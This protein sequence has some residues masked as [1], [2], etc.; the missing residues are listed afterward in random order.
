M[1]LRRHAGR[2]C[3]VVGRTSSVLHCLFSGSGW[4]S[5]ETGSGVPKA[6]G[7]GDAPLVGWTASPHSRPWVCFCCSPCGSAPRPAGA[8]AGPDEYCRAGALWCTP[9]AA[10]FL[11]DLSKRG[12]HLA[13][14][15]ET[16]VP[17]LAF[18]CTAGGGACAGAA[19]EPDGAAP[20]GPAARHVRGSATAQPGVPGGDLP[21]GQRAGWAGPAAA[22]R[23][24]QE[25]HFQGVHSGEALPVLVWDAAHHLSWPARCC[26]EEQ[27]VAAAGPSLCRWRWQCTSTWA[28][29]CCCKW[30][31]C[32][33]CCCCPWQRAGRRGRTARTAPPPSSC[34]R[35][36]WRA[37]WTSAR[38]RALHG[39][40]TSTLTAGGCQARRGA[41]S[42]CWRAAACGQPPGHV[43]RCRQTTA[44]LGWRRHCRLAGQSAWS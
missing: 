36:R 42:A 13:W 8:W 34:S 17:L 6:R 18:A 11:P 40:H 24:F 3:Q 39:T 21:G 32:W 9:P 30:R 33:R 27:S 20:A 12:L 31:R 16:G 37:C 26:A 41:I 29:T 19:R 2:R 44:V 14:P 38:S 5:L 4:A 23:A 15:L 25:V 7:P 22:A 35:W 1:A 10:T 43:P 28:A